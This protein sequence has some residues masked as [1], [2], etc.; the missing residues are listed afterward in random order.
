MTRKLIFAAMLACCGAIGAADVN[1]DTFIHG[2]STARPLEGTT[3]SA[4][5]GNALA[6]DAVASL[7]GSGMLNSGMLNSGFDGVASTF[8]EGFL[9]GAFSSTSPSGVFIIIR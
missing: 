4:E 5:S 6:L 3:M 2:G 7:S 9:T 1:L 8:S